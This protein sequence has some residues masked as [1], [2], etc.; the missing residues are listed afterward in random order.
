MGNVTLVHDCDIWRLADKTAWE[1]AFRDG[2]MKEDAPD[3]NFGGFTDLFAWY[4]YVSK[5]ELY[6]WRTFVRL[7][8]NAFIPASA[9]IVTAVWH[10]YIVQNALSD[11]MEI[12]AKR[13]T[14]TA[15]SEQYATWNKYDGVNAWSADHG[16]T[17][18][19][20]NFG[21][22]TDTGWKAFDLTDLANDAW[23]D[24]DGILAFILSRIDDLTTTSGGI[25]IQ[26]KFN[27][28]SP[29]TTTHHLRI[30]YTLDGR[31][32]QAVLR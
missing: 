9:V 24:R 1:G 21:Y 11:G 26:A 25:A 7:D 16:Q 18:P 31:T 27:G 6:D 14:D 3:T 19:D 15:I 4:A 22:F 12:H 30:T 28:E 29:Y 20:I 17:T 2:Y 13:T 8:L 23:A 5:E 10:V 32:F